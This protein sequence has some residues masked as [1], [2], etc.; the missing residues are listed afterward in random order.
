MRIAYILPSL[1]NQGP[2][3]VVKNITDYLVKWGHEPEIFYLDETSSKMTFKCPTRHIRMR[4]PID[5][6]RYDVIH[7]H[8]LRPDI[9]V[10]RW[11]KRICNA[12]TVSTLHQDTYRSFC[13]Q[14]NCVMSYLFT[15]YWSHIQSKFNGV[16][17]ISNQ[18][19]NLY[20]NKIKSPITTIYNGCFTHIDDSADI[21]IVDNL[22]Q[23]KSKYKLLGTYAYIT[24]RKGLGQ[25]IQALSYM[26]NYAF[27][28]IGE[29][30]DIANLKQKAQNLCVHDRVLFFP[31]QKN[32]CNYLPYFDVYVMPSYSEGFG[33]AMVE[34]ALAGKAIVC[35]DISSFHE[36][37]NE[38]EVRFFTLDNTDSLQQAIHSAY[39]NREK[40]GKA[41]YIKANNEFTAQ[42]MA[43]NHK[44]YYDNLLYNSNK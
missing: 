28:I 24:R 1:R 44:K 3:V 23:I 20:C 15:Q 35:S 22:K 29:G 9:Y 31:Y 14:Y 8:C 42:K 5:F 21:Q 40:L 36:I 33:M 17:S 43:E 37:F 16:I 19:K 25:I 27:V 18:L 10:Y 26:K 30:P 6:D 38:N 34:A 13:Y 11:R 2:I 12:K 32:P 39:I 4:T 7:S 41:A